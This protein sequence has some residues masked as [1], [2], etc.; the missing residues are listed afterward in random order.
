MRATRLVAAALVLGLAACGCGS[1]LLK[2]RGRVLK[3]GAPFLP[4]EGQFVRVTFVPVVEGGRAKDF[5]VAEVNREDGTFQVAGKD[6]RGMPPGR[7]RVAVE[8]DR[9]RSDL[10]R[11][12]F[13]AENSPFVFDV[14]SG[15]GEIII[16]LDKPPP[17]K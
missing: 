12:K 8:L 7:Y 10:L 2:T 3:N 16:D 14:D 11:G 9:H 6:L 17:K 1:N 13:D 4:G 15:T 5:Y